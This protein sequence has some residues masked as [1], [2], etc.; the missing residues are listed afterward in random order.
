MGNVVITA[1]RV[2]AAKHKNL[3]WFCYVS[4]NDA[5]HTHNIFK[6]T[7]SLPITQIYLFWAW[8]NKYCRCIKILSKYKLKINKSTSFRHN[9]LNYPYAPLTLNTYLQCLFYQSY[10]IGA[11]QVIF[12]LI[13]LA[14]KW[15]SSQEN[16][17]LAWICFIGSTT[18]IIPS[19]AA[20]L[21]NYFLT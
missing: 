19:Q 16:V 1:R 17:K 7:L 11:A 21:L 6:G 3:A 18:G 15:R 9:V 8:T 13:T 4:F 14:G 12:S 20:N 10:L 2:E 5:E